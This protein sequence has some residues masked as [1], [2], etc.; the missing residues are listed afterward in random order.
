MFADLQD[1]GNAQSHL[2]Y[3]AIARHADWD[4]GE[5]YP[6]VK[7]I[8][9]MAKCSEKT[10][11]RHL[12]KLEDDGLIEREPRKRKD[13]GRDADL[14]RMVNYKKWID[15][16]RNGGRV[17]KPVRIAKYEDTPLVNVSR[18]PG[19][20]VSRPPGQ[21]GVQGKEHQ[22]NSQKSDQRSVDLKSDSRKPAQ[23]PRYVSEAALAQVRRMSPGWDCQELLRRFLA[24]DGSKSAQNMDRAF[25]GWARKAT[26]GKPPPGLVSLKMM[27]KLQDWEL[28]DA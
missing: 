24:W 4:T 2:V 10:A 3:L 16:N 26:K 6:C 28:E 19:Q 27:P 21:Q 17:E 15:A 12:A 23:A 18:A 5:C 9:R 1:V 22:S 25:I 13:G 8:A 11:R 14:L 7:T 20:E